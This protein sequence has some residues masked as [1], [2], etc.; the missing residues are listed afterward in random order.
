ME[1]GNEL[2]YV[3]CPMNALSLGITTQQVPDQK[4]VVPVESGE[5]NNC[6]KIGDTFGQRTS[7]YRGVTS[8]QQ[9]IL[10]LMCADIG[11]VV[12]TKHIFGIIVVEERVKQGKDVK[13]RYALFGSYSYLF[14]NGYPSSDFRSQISLT[15][16]SD[17]VVCAT[18]F[19]YS[20]HLLAP[21]KLLKFVK[22]G[23]IAAMILVWQY[24]E[25][26]GYESWKG[27]SRSMVPLL[28]GGAFCACAWHFF[29]NSE[30]L[31]RVVV[32]T[33]GGVVRALGQRAYTGTGQRAGRILNVSV[34]V[35]QLL[36]PDQWEIKS[37]GDVNHLNG[38]GYLESGIGGHRTSGDEKLQEMKEFEEEGEKLMKLHEEKKAEMKSSHW[39]EEID[40]EEGCNTDLMDKYTPKDKVQG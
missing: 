35:F 18:G 31:E 13:I 1:S 23:R 34:N 40:L 39:K 21:W 27:L 8:K 4:T 3:Q 16:D 32:V 10:C 36:E 30:S 22:F 20:W 5:Q 9:D 17:A 37:W 14:I 15:D 38:A 28:L 29:Y 25:K 24:G 26:S 33:H 19:Q 7:I 11:G 6:K 12:D 2:A